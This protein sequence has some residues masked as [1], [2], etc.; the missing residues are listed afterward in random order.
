[1]LTDTKKKEQIEFS[2][3]IYLIFISLNVY[4]GNETDASLYRGVSHNQDFLEA[5]ND[6]S[7]SELREKFRS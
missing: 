2:K 7:L 5:I 1:M 6:Q 3:E 4:K